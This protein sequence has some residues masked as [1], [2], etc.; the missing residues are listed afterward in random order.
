MLFMKQVED[1]R[2]G[3]SVAVGNLH[4]K[5]SVSFRVEVEMQ[6]V[7]EIELLYLEVVANA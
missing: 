1:R 3:D 2:I 5:P 6:A 4:F 7:V